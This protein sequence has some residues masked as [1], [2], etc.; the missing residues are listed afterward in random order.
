MSQTEQDKARLKS[1]YLRGA[2]D[3]AWLGLY[4]IVIF[5]LMVGSLNYPILNIPGFAMMIGVPFLTYFFIRRTHV[6]AHGISA[7]SALWMQGIVMFGCGSLLLSAFGYVFMRWISPGFIVGLL[8]QAQ[9]VYSGLP[10]ET[11]Q[12]MAK[13]IGLLLES[14]YVPTPQTVVMG[15]LWLGMFSGSLL[16]MVIAGLARIKRV[17]ISD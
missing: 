8:Q 17:P 4:L 1:I 6:A 14:R 2:E 13:E 3:G 5:A 7:F 11:A 12:E 9:D 16:S 15:W 10:D